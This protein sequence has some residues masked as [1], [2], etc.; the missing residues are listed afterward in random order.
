MWTSHDLIVV[1][2]AAVAA[3]MVCLVALLAND[4]LAA[5]TMALGMSVHQPREASEQQA[6]RFS[7]RAR[8]EP[9]WYLA[10]SDTRWM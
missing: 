3:S 4:V 9:V 5:E 6:A 10:G 7:K 8:N 1:A 2:H